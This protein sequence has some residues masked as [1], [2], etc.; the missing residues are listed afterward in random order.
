MK[1]SRLS[2]FLLIYL[3]IWKQNFTNGILFQKIFWP[4]VREKCFFW[5]RT[6]CDI[7]NRTFSQLFKGDFSDVKIATMKNPIGTSRFNLKTLEDELFYA[8]ISFCFSSTNAR[9]LLLVG[10]FYR[11]IKK[12]WWPQAP[13]LRKFLIITGAAM[14]QKYSQ[15]I[16]NVEFYK[17]T[18]KSR[19]SWQSLEISSLADQFE[20]VYNLI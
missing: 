20:F 12:K 1:I 4:T 18:K 15:V 14:L 13:I 9:Y 11:R 2:K 17:F 6:V 3:C 7:W 10:I 16:S 8:I 19:F 5:L